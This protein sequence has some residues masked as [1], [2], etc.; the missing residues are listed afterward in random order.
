MCFLL[1]RDTDGYPNLATMFPETENWKGSADKS[2]SL[3]P[4]YPKIQ[5]KL[6]FV[7]CRI[8]HVGISATI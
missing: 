8:I 5:L 3:L 1:R 7:F 6:N 4:L 2:V